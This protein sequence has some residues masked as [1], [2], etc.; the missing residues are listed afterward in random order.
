MIVLLEYLGTNMDETLDSS[1]M[2]M[3][4][5]MSNLS[6]DDSISSGIDSSD[7]DAE[8]IEGFVDFPKPAKEPRSYAFHDRRIWQAAM[9]MNPEV[10]R[11]HFRVTKGKWPLI[12]WSWQTLVQP[13]L[14]MK[15]GNMASAIR[16]C[17]ASIV[18]ST[19]YRQEL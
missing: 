7:S 18:T 13:L 19:L 16:V 12:C 5:H 2:S 11:S 9:K 6:N 1:F 15:R 14:F 3:L 17:M 10:F 8:V 4:S